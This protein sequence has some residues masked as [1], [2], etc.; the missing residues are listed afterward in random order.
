M[1]YSD[2]LITFNTEITSIANTMNKIHLSS[3]VYNKF[4]ST[5]YDNKYDG[6][7]MLFKQYTVNFW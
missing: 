4:T 7:G 6:I 2:S 1:Y 3:T 5:Y